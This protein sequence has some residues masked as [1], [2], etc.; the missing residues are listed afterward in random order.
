MPAKGFVH[1]TKN[2]YSD[3]K[4]IHAYR[5]KEGTRPSDA[6]ASIKTSI[7]FIDCQ[8][9]IQIAYYEVLLEV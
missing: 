3:F 8:E 1:L 6:L 9:A 2:N 7:S 5:L 4:L